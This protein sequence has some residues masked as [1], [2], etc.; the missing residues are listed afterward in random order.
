M[1]KT[2]ANQLAKGAI[3]DDFFPLPTFRRSDIDF[4]DLSPSIDSWGSLLKP[5]QKD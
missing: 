4:G 1:F 5:E 3:P 2:S